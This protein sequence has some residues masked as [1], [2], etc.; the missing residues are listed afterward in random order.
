MDFY[1]V[2]QPAWLESKFPDL[3]KRVRKPAVALVA[4]D[5]TWIVFMK[6]RLDRVLQL[7]L[8]EMTAE[9][10]T[11]SMGDIPEF[12]NPMPPMPYAPYA[13]GWWKVFERK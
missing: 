1:M 13:H 11:Q 3:D 8:G 9:E 12:K 10:V 7:D 2:S 5:K 6:L 4:T